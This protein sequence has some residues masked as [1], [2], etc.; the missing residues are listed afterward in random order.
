MNPDR[1]RINRSDKGERKGE[2]ISQRPF[3]DSLDHG[4]TNLSRLFKPR[5]EEIGGF[6]KPLLVQPEASV[7]HAT[8]PPSGRDHEFQVV[9]TVGLIM[10][11][12]MNGTVETGLRTEEN[13]G[14]ADPH[15]EQRSRR[16]VEVNKRLDIELCPAIDHGQQ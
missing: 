7:G 9:G 1:Q 12:G 3:H 6:T 14:D 15:P 10:D 13:L 11:G 8:T 4:G 2:S 5:F 16:E